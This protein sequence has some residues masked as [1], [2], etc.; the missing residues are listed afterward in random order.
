MMS[1]RPVSQI[2]VSSI[3]QSMLSETLL[4]SSQDGQSSYTQT[5]P[6]SHLLTSTVQAPTRAANGTSAMPSVQA[7]TGAASSVRG[8]VFGLAAGVL[9]VAML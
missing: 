8:S 9:A 4:T 1:S 5:H 3:N 7:Y 2:G 6:S